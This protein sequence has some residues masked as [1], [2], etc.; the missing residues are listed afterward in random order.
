[1]KFSGLSIAV[2]SVLLGRMPGKIASQLKK[3]KKPEKM[4]D[5]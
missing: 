3:V 5:P 1:M 2:S 4:V